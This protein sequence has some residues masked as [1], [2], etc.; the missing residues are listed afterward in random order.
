M[1]GDMRMDGASPFCHVAIGL[2]SVALS[3]AEVPVVSILQTLLGGGHASQTHL[4]GGSLSRLNARVIKQNPYVESCTAFSTSYSDGGLFGVYGVAQAEKGAELC[5]SLTASLTGLKSI[6]AEEL[7]GAKAVLK[8]NLL[9]QADDDATFL[10]DLAQQLL[11]AGGY[12]SPSAFAKA[13]DGVTVEQAQA[14]A[15]KLLGSRPTLAAFGDVHAVPHY[16]SVE[17]ALRA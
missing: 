16:G 4:G 15:T 10:Q 2:E 1:G 8:A 12:A 6:T 14:V 7:N 3:S 11:F 13:V 5:N 17:A 9:R